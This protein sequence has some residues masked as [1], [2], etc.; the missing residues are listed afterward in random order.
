MPPVQMETSTSKVVVHARR[1]QES[2]L[3]WVELLDE[4]RAPAPSPYFDTRLR[5]RLRTEPDAPKP[6]W[7]IARITRLGWW[8]ASVSLLAGFL[9]VFGFFVAAPR[10]VSTESLSDTSAVV[11]LQ[12]LDR[13]ADLLS[14]MSWLE[15]ADDPEFD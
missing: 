11:D 15:N 14:E 1:K 3:Q 9:V 10:P 8:F 13:D 12:S 7:K 4:W 2:C 5:A 6:F